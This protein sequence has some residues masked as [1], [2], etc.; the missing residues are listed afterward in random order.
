ML[1]TDSSSSSSTKR[2]KEKKVAFTPSAPSVP[3]YCSHKRTGT[4]WKLDNF[5]QSSR[6]HFLKTLKMQIVHQLFN[7]SQIGAC[8][9]VKLNSFRLVRISKYSLASP[10]YYNLSMQFPGGERGSFN[11][12]QNC[13]QK[14]A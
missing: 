4:T 14:S 10:A 11:K 13:N 3:L 1:C 9:N 2:H 7:A 12:I 5:Q 6:V 8:I